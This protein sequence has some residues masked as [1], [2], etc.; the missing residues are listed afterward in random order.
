MRIVTD[1]PRRARRIDNAWIPLKDGARLASRMWLPEDADSR[2][3]P[4]ILEYIPY[5]KGDFTAA[6]DEPMH[7]WFAGHGYAAVR[8]D[9]RGSGDSDGVLLD[10]YLQR[11]L[12]DAVEVIAWLAKQP[13]CTGAVGMMGNSWG[14]FNAL[15]VA[16]LRPPALKAIITSCSTDDRYADDMHYM[17]GCLLN[18]NMDW[19]AT[20]F[21]FLP[22]P[23][24]PAVVGERWRAMWLE[25][26]EKL[27]QPIE[28]WL[29]HQ[30][31]DAYWKHGSVCEDYGAIECPVFAVGGWLDGYSNA[32]ARLLAGLK[33]PRRAVI[34]P[35]AHM[36][37]HTALPGPG[38]DFLG[39]AVR[40]WDHWL[41]GED[42][43]AMAEPMLRAWMGEAIPA[44]PFYQTCPGRWVAETA[45]PSPRTAAHRLV[46]NARR[47]DPEPAAETRLDFRSPQTTGLAGGEWCPYGTGGQGPEFPGDQREDDGRSLVFDSEPLQSRLEILG[48]PVATLDLAVDRPVAFVAVRLCDVA[49]DGASTRVSY[50]VLNLAHRN[51]FER[52]ERIEPGRRMHVRVRLND[53][54]YAFRPEHRLR[55]ALSTTYWPMVWPSPEPVLLSLF[56]GAGTLTLPARPPRPEDAGLPS[57]GEPASAPPLDRTQ[58]EAGRWENAVSRDLKSGLVTVTAT[59]HDGLWRLDDTGIEI[60]GGMRERMSI[61]E[62][63]PLSAETE[64]ARTIQIG[65]GEWR[66]RIEATTR[67]TATR[68]AFISTARLEAHEDDRRIFARDWSRS[69]PR[70]SR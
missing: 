36:F 22:R 3:V 34:G 63:D 69:I 40:W 65:R 13:W 24:D 12:D 47:L 14:G 58:L 68:E 5:R 55:L 2:P 10:E 6:R 8:V 60:G 21:A 46:L 28:I 7:R 66:T 48:A 32:I 64:M 42:R 25:R 11:E 56:T 50:G 61:T 43:G 45:W 39:E 49:P 18:D 33:V 16:A 53:A 15:Q 41:R 30:R 1:F 31:R 26:L 70:D 67:L 57:L 38:F 29:E 37:P 19:G 54:A 9:L 59:R 17:G 51:G 44:V 35:W 52:V 4:A 62:G 27:V 23:P 20:F